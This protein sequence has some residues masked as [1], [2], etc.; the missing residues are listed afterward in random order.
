MIYLDIVSR[1]LIF[2]FEL[3]GVWIVYRMSGLFA[4]D[5]KTKYSENTFRKVFGRMYFYSVAIIVALFV[6][7]MLSYAKHNSFE[8]MGE[9]FLIITLTTAAGAEDIFSNNKKDKL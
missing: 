6:S 9:V 1:V 3:V 5:F 4:Q 7:F 8:F 2:F